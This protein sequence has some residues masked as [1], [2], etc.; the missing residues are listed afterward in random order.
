VTAVSITALP[1]VEAAGGSLRNRS[2]LESNMTEPRQQG[3]QPGRTRS[4]S[5]RRVLRTGLIVLAV[6][7]VVWFVAANTKQ[8]TVQW[9]V[10]ETSS[11]LFLVIIVSAVLGALI[12]RLIVWRGRRRK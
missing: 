11:P 12:D 3:G 6:A 10:V 1:L 8:V 5:A 9:F 4:E 2:S 7:A